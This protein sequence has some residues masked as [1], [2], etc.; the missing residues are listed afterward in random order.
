VYG[1]TNPKAWEP[2]GKPIHRFVSANKDCVPCDKT[3][4]EGFT[5]MDSITSEEVLAE[6]RKLI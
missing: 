2:E 3:E 4:C 5:C 6:F 1:A